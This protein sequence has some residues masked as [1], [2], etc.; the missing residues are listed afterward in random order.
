MNHFRV[1][2]IFRRKNVKK[3]G[4]KQNNLQFVSETKCPPDKKQQQP[5][6]WRTFGAWTLKTEQH[7]IEFK[8]FYG[9]TIKISNYRD[10]LTANTILSYNTIDI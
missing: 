4:T 3:K 8:L 1:A 7:C 9:L 10:P 2:W 5:Q 6:Q